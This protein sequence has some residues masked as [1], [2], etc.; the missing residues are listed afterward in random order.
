ML[1][2]CFRQDGGKKKSN[3]KYNEVNHKGQLLTCLTNVARE[4]YVKATA[5]VILRTILP[6]FREAPSVRHD[7]D[8]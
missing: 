8:N 6:L 2:V 3:S 7:L 1:H 4:D 5:L